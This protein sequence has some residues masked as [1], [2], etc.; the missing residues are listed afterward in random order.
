MKKLLCGLTL[1]VSMTCFA[2]LNDAYEV[3]LTTYTQDGCIVANGDYEIR[4][5]NSMLKYGV[6]LAECST[7][8]NPFVVNRDGDLSVLVTRSDSDS[9][10]ALE[11]F[12]QDVCEL[13]GHTGLESIEVGVM[14]SC[15][16]N[17]SNCFTL[18]RRGAMEFEI[19]AIG[20]RYRSRPL[21]HLLNVG[22]GLLG[23]SWSY[24]TTSVE[25]YHDGRYLVKTLKC[26]D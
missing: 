8:L 9:K 19:E 4:S 13:M 7:E 24:N 20:D 18:N 3:N 1:L 10:R 16:P 5:S 23:G 25:D 21:G 26:I 14:I 17:E 15:I 12:G 2:G 22:N 11:S 6:N